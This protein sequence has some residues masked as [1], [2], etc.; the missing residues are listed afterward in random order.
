MTMKSAYCS[1]CGALSLR[2][3]NS[4]G[5]A[6]VSALGVGSAIMLDYLGDREAA[7]GQARDIMPRY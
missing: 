7:I 3:R 2:T 6:E 4:A 1:E 5:N